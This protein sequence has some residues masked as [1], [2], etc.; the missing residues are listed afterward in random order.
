MRTLIRVSGLLGVS[1]PLCVNLL[2]SVSCR[3][4]DSLMSTVA[5]CSPNG[6][7]IKLSYEEAQCIGFLRAARE[8]DSLDAEGTSSFLVPF[9]PTTL[10]H[11]V[12]HCQEFA[13]A[14]AGAWP[15]RVVGASCLN[16]LKRL[17]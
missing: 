3:D 15:A 5:L 11:L 2:K 8:L 7:Q 10:Q 13:R 16:R 14:K 4:V 12:Q 9:A 1:G 6:Q 17:E